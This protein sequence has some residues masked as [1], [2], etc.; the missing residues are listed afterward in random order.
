MRTATPGDWKSVANGLVVL[1][2]NNVLW[3]SSAKGAGQG[4]TKMED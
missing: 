3:I 2:C 4:D 1:R